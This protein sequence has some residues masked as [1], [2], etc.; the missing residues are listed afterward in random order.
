MQLLLAGSDPLDVYKGGSTRLSK[1]PQW[2]RRVSLCLNS[3]DHDK[4]YDEVM[5]TARDG[6]VHNESE[7][8][9]AKS[10]YR[11]LMIVMP[12]KFRLIGKVLKV[13]PS[14]IHDT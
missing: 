10:G 7:L 6:Y 5:R 11:K 14:C 13:C 9:D 3:F 2:S 4:F 12:G 1:H 8:I